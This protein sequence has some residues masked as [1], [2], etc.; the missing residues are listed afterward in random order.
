MSPRSARA[1]AQQYPTAPLD[2]PT[3]ATFDA[4]VYFIPAA[5]AQYWL[6]TFN[7]H[8]RN[9]VASRVTALRADIDN[10]DW[11]LNGDAIRFGIT[12]EGE[13]VLLD[14]QHRLA[15]VAASEGTIPSL[16]ITGLPADTQET[17]D[18]GARRSF[19]DVLTLRG[20]ENTSA[21]GAF[22]NRVYMW[23]NGTTRAAGSGKTK[24]TV[25]QLLRKWQELER[26]TD[27]KEHLTRGSNL[28]KKLHAAPSMFALCSYVFSEVERNQAG[29][30]DKGTDEELPDTAH[31]FARLFDGE[32]LVDGSPILSLRNMFFTNQASKQRYPDLTLLAM[33]IKAWNAYRDGK[34]LRVV[35]W[36]SGG[37][38]PEPFPEPR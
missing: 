16:V 5:A 1:I 4:Q 11:K 34:P 27:I 6:D 32:A 29:G 10:G 18:F 13:T 28:G 14:G 20:A 9:L 38:S 19:P 17:M 31:F 35:V 15:A 2:L 23:E 12:P 22:V 30:P 26:T 3:N 24:A 8:N 33:T 36:R 21:M 7:L 25:A 37:R